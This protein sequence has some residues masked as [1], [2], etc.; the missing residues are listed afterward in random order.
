MVFHARTTTTVEII[1]VYMTHI[2]LTGAGFSRNWGGWLTDEVFEYLLGCP[3]INQDIQTALWRSKNSKLGFENTL[4]DLRAEAEKHK[5]DR[6]TSN[7]KTFE[8]MLEGM[9]DSMN[10]GFKMVRFNPLVPSFT[11]GPEHDPDHIRHFLASFDAIFTLN[12]DCLLELKCNEP[13]FHQLSEGR[14]RDMYCP[15]LK[16]LTANGTPYGP[17]GLFEPDSKLYQIEPHQQPYFKLHG[18]SN[19]RTGDSTLLVMG[20]NK[21]QDIEKHFLLRSYHARFTSILQKPDTRLVIIGYS[22]RDPHINEKILNGIKTGLKLFL[23]D[24]NGID[25]LSDEI[26][27]P[28]N[29]SMTLRQAIYGSILGASR[30]SLN[31]TF[32]GDQVEH[33]K[34]RR[35][36]TRIGPPSPMT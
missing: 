13:G 29:N 19:W 21:G 35:F 6:P 24:P 8:R 12:Q 36:L 4:Q 30:R 16:P 1:A 3:E 5:H 26:R 22:F 25:V 33:A 31:S 17:P 20:G 2:L 34:I 10:N 28:T 32:G 9:F 18:S 7:V 14:W 15:G 27:V 11:R 23:I